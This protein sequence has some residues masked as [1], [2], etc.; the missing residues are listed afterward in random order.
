L[1]VSDVDAET[2]IPWCQEILRE[3]YYTA[4]VS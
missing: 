3:V 2:I 1:T 4:Q